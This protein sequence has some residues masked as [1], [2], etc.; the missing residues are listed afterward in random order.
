MDEIDKA[1]HAV[2]DDQASNQSAVNA[3]T[4][5]QHH[6]SRCQACTENPPQGKYWKPSPKRIGGYTVIY[7]HVSK[8]NWSASVPDLP[9]LAVGGYTKEEVEK[10]I[11]E[12][13]VFHIEGLKEDGLPVPPPRQS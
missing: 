6:V 2:A 12:G 1:I 13:I 3:T 9:G 10:K 11:Q 4:A 5:F 8:D 7:E